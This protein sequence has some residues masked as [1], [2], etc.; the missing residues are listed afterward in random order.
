METPKEPPA[1]K[2]AQLQHSAPSFTKALFRIA[3]TFL[4]A[5]T[6]SPP[7]YA[8]RPFNGTDAAVADVGELEFELQ[9]AG[10]LQEGGTQTLVAPWLVTNF[11]FA[12]NWEAVLARR[13]AANPALL[14]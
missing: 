11:G 12:K 7:V 13:Q 14:R 9:P 10:V 8:Y 2:E 3:A 6:F 1:G 4:V 5:C